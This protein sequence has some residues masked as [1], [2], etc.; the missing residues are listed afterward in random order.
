[1]VVDA[2]LAVM[3]VVL[4]DVAVFFVVVGVVMVPTLSLKLPWG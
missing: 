3:V 1:M 4:M 2:L